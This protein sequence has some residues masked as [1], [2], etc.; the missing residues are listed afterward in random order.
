MEIILI[1]VA[2]AF[3]FAILMHK[4]RNGRVF[5]ALIDFITMITLGSLFGGTL[6]GMVIAMISGAL[7]STYLWFAPFKITISKE[8]KSKVLDI[9]GKTIAVL[10]IVA[11]LVA[12]AL[13]YT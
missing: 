13:R 3:N 12:I 6:G 4:F 11:V 7:I 5:D 10:L 2:T 9:L 1:A 8:F